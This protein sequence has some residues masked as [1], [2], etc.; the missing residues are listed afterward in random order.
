MMN[1]KQSKSA[2]LYPQKVTPQEV[3]RLSL[4]Q[5][6]ILPEIRPLKVI[7]ILNLKILK[8]GLLFG[9]FLVLIK[10]MEEML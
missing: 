3:I 10:V 7:L 9:V 6:N 2:L 4:N 5:D 8:K 1:R